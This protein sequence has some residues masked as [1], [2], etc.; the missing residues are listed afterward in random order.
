MGHPRK[1]AAADREKAKKVATKEEVANKNEEARWKDDGDKATKAKLTRQAELETKSAEQARKLKEKQDLI[2]AEESEVIKSSKKVM[3][4]KINQANIR[5]S[6]LAGIQVGKKPAAPRTI[7]DKDLV[8]NANKMIMQEERATGI[9]YEAGSGTVG[10]MSAL[11][12]ALDKA[13][14]DAHPERRMKTAHTAFEEQRLKELLMDK[15]GLK[16][17]QYKDMIWKEWQK[18]PE[19]PMYDP[20]SK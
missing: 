17:S 11:T 2:K 20:N 5:I 16:R 1:E 9:K 15:P 14:Q 10:A 7:F 12:S 6:A 3:P 18:S 8:P 4:T 13:A 19:N